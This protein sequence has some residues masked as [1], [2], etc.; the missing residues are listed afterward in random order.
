[1]LSLRSLPG[2][3]GSGCKERQYLG[4]SGLATS[5][6]LCRQRSTGS[7]SPWGGPLWWMLNSPRADSC[8]R[9]PSEWSQRLPTY[10]PLH[11][12]TRMPLATTSG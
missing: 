5:A 2:L 3:A 12:A 9:S 7:V 8:V 4:G 6:W 10:S 1:M 11:G